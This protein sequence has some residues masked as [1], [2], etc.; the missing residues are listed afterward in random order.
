[1]KIFPE[2][3]TAQLERSLAPI[4]FVAGPEL[5]LVEEACDAIRNAARAQG[6]VE[7]VVIDA[8]AR[9]DWN[10]L[11]AAGDN[12]SL[13]A[14]RRLIELRLPSGKPGREGGA[15]LREWAGNGSDDV[16][17]IKSQAW[18]LASEKTAWFRDVEQAGV[19]VPC[20]SVK[21]HR[22]P[23][24]IR[25][26]LAQRGVS[27]DEA[28]CTFL[29]ER[30]EG[31]LLAAAQETE[32]LGLL[33]GRGGQLNLDQLRE[34]VADSARFDSFR[35]VELVMTGQAGAAARCIRGL[36]EGD[37]PMPMI[38][39]AL[40]RELQTIEAFQT[41][42]RQMPPARAV[43]EL[44]LWRSREEAI[45]SA[46]RRLDPGMVRQALSRLSDL[47]L[48]SKSS[49]KHEFW[50]GLERLCVGLARNRLETAA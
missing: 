25:Q 26:R 11:G 35:L 15:A 5:L 49:N 50:L 4:Y 3:L 21:P 45:Q 19:F 30:L 40:A 29:A 48:L 43:A 6:I 23:Q 39:F 31:N 8:D 17:L 32:R 2:K 42:C 28:A 33:Y 47:D 22:L 1:V 14:T 37:V 18:E 41:L 24:W 9:Y 13:F 38:V 10:Q 46:A 16:L 34:A 12:L 20:W 27:A 44:K 36:A 7:R